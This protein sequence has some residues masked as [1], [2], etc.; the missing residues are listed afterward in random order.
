MHYVLIPKQQY[1]NNTNK[2]WANKNTFCTKRKQD[3]NSFNSILGKHTPKM[4][5]WMTKCFFF[6]MW[7]LEGKKEKGE[8]KRKE[9]RSKWCARKRKAENKNICGNRERKCSENELIFPH[10]LAPE[11]LILW[12]NIYK[13]ICCTKQILRRRYKASREKRNKVKKREKLLARW[14]KPLRHLMRKINIFLLGQIEYF[15]WWK[16]KNEKSLSLIKV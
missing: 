3:R 5:T 12:Y 9:C 1:S 16:W 2:T 6:S 7:H 13:D 8:R 10:S 4:V 15:L 14:K 11:A